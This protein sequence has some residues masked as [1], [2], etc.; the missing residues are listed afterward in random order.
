[1]IKITNK[2]SQ[3]L[4]Y[5]GDKFQSTVKTISERL[6]PAFNVAPD[7]SSDVQYEWICETEDGDL[8][9]ICD[10][11]SEKNLNVYKPTT[12]HISA[13]NKRISK[14]ALYEIR[15]LRLHIV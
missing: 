6:G 10:H 13:M 5:H 12:F 7:G 8:F 2:F 15:Q 9:N 1:M 11:K 14:L 3:G 4:N